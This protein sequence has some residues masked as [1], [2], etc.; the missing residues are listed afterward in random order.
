MM[1]KQIYFVC[2]ITVITIHKKVTSIQ[3]FWLPCAHTVLQ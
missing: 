2:M 3:C 1:E